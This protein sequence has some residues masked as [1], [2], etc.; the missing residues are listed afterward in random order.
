[1]LSAKLCGQEPDQVESG[2]AGASSKP[3]P[4]TCRPQLLRKQNTAAN[5]RLFYL[6]WHFG[7]SSP[8]LTLPDYGAL[9][10]CS[11]ASD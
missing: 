1:M 9:A 2:P 7:T 11:H 4:V 3:R 10:A 5:R 6:G 8:K